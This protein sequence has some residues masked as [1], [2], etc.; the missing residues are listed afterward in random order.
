MPVMTDDELQE[1][2]DGLT[3]M[4]EWHRPEQ[5]HLYHNW[6][7]S[8]TMAW[9]TVSEVRLRKDADHPWKKTGAGLYIND[10]TA[11]WGD[12]G[13]NIT[14]PFVTSVWQFGLF[15]VV[16]RSS[17]ELGSD[18]GA[19]YEFLAVDGQLSFNARL[20]R[21]SLG[22]CDAEYGPQFIWRDGI[23]LERKRIHTMLDEF[24]E[25]IRRIDHAVI[26]TEEV[27]QRLLEI[28]LTE[29]NGYFGVNENDHLHADR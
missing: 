24:V 27:A 18:E 14:L 15:Y 20:H 29:G 8:S 17:F 23:A 3:G 10:R 16:P 11:T 9:G 22:R 2:R 26:G 1:L 4:L 25:S 28:S 7:D 12:P 13:W 6:T 21:H 5:H 19:Y